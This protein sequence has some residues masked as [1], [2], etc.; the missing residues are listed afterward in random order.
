MLLNVQCNP[1]Y[2]VVM[3]ICIDGFRSILTRVLN[4]VLL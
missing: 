4:L 1:I 3:G 2:I